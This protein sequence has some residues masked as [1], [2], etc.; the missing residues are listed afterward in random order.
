MNCVYLF[1]SSYFINFSVVTVLS[2][3]P[4]P[5]PA[6]GPRPPR[7]IMVI[8]YSIFNFRVLL[9]AL[10][11]SVA[12]EL[13]LFAEGKNLCSSNRCVQGTLSSFLGQSPMRK[14][15]P[16]GYAMY[17]QIHGS[18]QKK[19]RKVGMNARNVKW[20]YHWTLLSKIYSH[21][22]LNSLQFYLSYFNI[23]F[24][25]FIGIKYG[26]RKLYVN[27]LNFSSLTSCIKI[28]PD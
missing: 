28:E 21:M 24:L 13:V 20:L 5:A 8:S 1:H 12:T 17:A 25:N 22:V 26:S 4:H 19:G 16:Q 27:V 3:P 7:P 6:P 18:K 2:A 9:L 15:G 11:V 14:K 23:L 10:F